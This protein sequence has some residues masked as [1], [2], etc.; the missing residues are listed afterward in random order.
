MAKLIFD[1]GLIGTGF[2]P[3]P[4]GSLI[5]PGLKSK[6]ESVMLDIEFDA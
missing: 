4:H 1:H 5:D 3:N 2:W 6:T